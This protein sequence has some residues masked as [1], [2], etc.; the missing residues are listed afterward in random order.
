MAKI[1]VVNGPSYASALANLGEITH[2]PSQL[3][4]EGSKFKLVL[5]TGGEDITPSYYEDKSP[6]GMCYYNEHRDKAEAE[7]L[8]IARALDIRCI[9]ICRGV[10]FLNVMAGGKMFHDVDNHAGQYHNMATKTG[11]LIRVNSLHHQMIIPPENS[12]LIGWASEHRATRYY[13]VNDTLVE[14]PKVEPEA[15]LLPGLQSAG[16]QYHPEMMAEN[17]DGWR[18]F[19]ELAKDLIEIENFDTIIEKYTGASCTKQ[20]TQSEQS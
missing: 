1:L 10:Q 18:F 3:V 17:T 13:G 19:N 7:I 8:G 16:V 2:D 20:S 5:F 4:T 11:G 9:G 12:H 6:K 15:I 14:A